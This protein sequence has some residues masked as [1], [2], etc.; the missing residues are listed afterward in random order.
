MGDQ[1]RGAVK[2]GQQTAHFAFHSFAQVTVQRAEGLVQHQDARPPGKDAGQCGA[3]L[4]PAGKLGRVPLCQRLQ[5]HGPQQFGAA[6]LPG[7][8]VFFGFQAAENVL[9]HRHIREESIILEQQPCAP[10]LRRQVDVLL[11]VKQYPPVQHD[12]AFVRLHDAGNAAQ[13][14]AFAAAGRAQQGS[15]DV[16]GGKCSPQGEAIQLLFNVHFQAHARPPAFCCFSSRFTAS[17]TTAE[18]TMST[19]T[20]RRAPASSL[21]RQS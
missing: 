5:P 21:V 7:S 19:S 10:L 15:G 9:F 6:R 18:M 12:A 4:L 16:S 20:Q 17:S 13:G 8:A 2:P 3:L 1:K 11:T 14:H